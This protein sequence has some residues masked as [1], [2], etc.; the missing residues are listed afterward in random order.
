L[1]GTLII[2]NQI[3]WSSRGAFLGQA[4]E[5]ELVVEV[6]VKKPIVHEAIDQPIDFRL[7][8]VAECPEVRR[9][10]SL[11]SALDR[12]LEQTD[13]PGLADRERGAGDGLQDGDRIG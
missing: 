7:L 3:V 4:K 13:Q 1:N 5:L 8:Q 2:G 6:A 11:D 12:S 10:I 9:A